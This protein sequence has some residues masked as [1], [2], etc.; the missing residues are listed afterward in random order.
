MRKSAEVAAPLKRRSFVG[1][2]AAVAA[3]LFAGPSWV[4]RIVR[5]SAEPLHTQKKLRVSIN[6]LAVPRRRKGANTNG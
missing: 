2:A 1:V 5:P 6:P 3:A 4:A